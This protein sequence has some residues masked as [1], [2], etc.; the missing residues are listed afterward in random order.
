MTSDGHGPDGCWNGRGPVSDAQRTTQGRRMDKHPNEV[1]EPDRCLSPKTTLLASRSFSTP[2]ANPPRRDS[3]AR[4]FIYVH[5]QVILSCLH[6]GYGAAQIYQGLEDLGFHPPMS[7]RQFRRYVRRIK[8]AAELEGS[9]PH[10]IYRRSPPE[11]SPGPNPRN[12]MPKATLAPTSVPPQPSDTSTPRH[13]DT[14]TP[15]HRQTSHR[16]SIGIRRLT[17]MR[18]AD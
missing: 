17:S 13:L 11:P 16:P 14:S 8:V 5:A 6:A 18:F 4:A 10:A 2:W 3:H 1:R 9:P 7:T 12:G 15:R